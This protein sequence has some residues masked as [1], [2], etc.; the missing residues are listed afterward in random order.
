MANYTE[1]QTSDMKSLQSP[2]SE[3]LARYRLQQEALEAMHLSPFAVKS[4]ESLGREHPEPPCPLRTAFQRDRD[5]IIHCKA[6]RRLKHK[7]QVFFSPVGDHY[8]TRLTHTLE[9]SQV[10]RTIARALRLNEDLT[11]AIALGHDLGHPPFGHTGERCLNDVYPGGFHHYLQSVRV[12]RDIEKLN[13]SIEVLDSIAKDTGSEEP[14]FLEGQLVKL[15]DRMAYLHHDVEDAIRAGLMTESDLP[16]D[17]IATLGAEREE[18]LNRMILDMVTTSQAKLEAGEP[19]IGLSAEVSEAM[20]AL[21]AWMF[22]HIYLTPE[23]RRRGEK[24]QRLISGLYTYFCEN[25]NQLPEGSRAIETDPVE[26][27][28]VDYIAGMTDRF[29][30]EVYT[31]QLLPSPYQPQ[32]QEQPF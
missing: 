9:V 29:A 17:I 25:P 32:S 18:R 7:T 28:V 24:V 15:A 20:I 22:E 2:P 10:S 30:I 12:A 19:S 11:E 21:R 3:E 13:L 26:R 14:K 8:R 1:L 4:A 27:Q 6:F 31:T 16:K 23:Q 5:R